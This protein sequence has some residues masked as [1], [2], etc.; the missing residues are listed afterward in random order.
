MKLTE[1]QKAQILDLLSEDHD[2]STITKTV[3]NRDDIDGRC[4]EG[5]AVRRFVAK[6]GMSVKTTKNPK[7][8]DVELTDEQKLIIGEQ[9]EKGVSSSERIAKLIFGE[10]TPKLSKE[11]RVVHAYIESLGS[12]REESEE[13][14]ALPSYIPPK[15]TSKI[16]RKINESTGLELQ[17][18]KLN[19]YHSICCDRLRINLHNSRFQTIINNYYRGK[20]RVLFE[21]EFIRLTWDKPDLTADEINLYMNVSKEI[22]NL[23]LVSGQLQKLHQMFDDADDQSEMTIRLAEIVK[24]KGEEY[25]KCAKRIEDLTKKLQ[26][27]RGQRLQQKKEENASFLAIVREFQEEEGRKNMLRIAEMQKK[28]IKQEAERLESMDGWKVRILGVGKEDVI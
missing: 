6:R 26:G 21:Q 24:T 25:H 18:S 28:L 7:A 15:A 17:E 8:K 12:G 10:D 23:E 4:K 20:D 2:L 16:I 22:L 9:L 1:N 5:I 19:R 27:E 11:Q 13:D 3:F 14:G